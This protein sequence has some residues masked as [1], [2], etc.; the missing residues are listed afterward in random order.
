[1]KK[2]EPF[3]KK[4]NQISDF[5]ECSKEVKSALRSGIPNEFKRG[6]ILKLFQVNSENT[7]L[8]FEVASQ[9]VFTTNANISLDHVSLS[10][11]RHLH[12][13]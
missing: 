9:K 11:F 7:K 8:A 1:M 2:Y 5:L 6:F 10:R 3:I 4:F 12:I 13:F